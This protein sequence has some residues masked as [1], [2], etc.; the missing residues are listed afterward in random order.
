MTVYPSTDGKKK[1]R[2][3]QTYN[4]VVVDAVGLAP[5]AHD[6]VV[7]VGDEDDLVDPFGFELVAL[8]DEARDVL[9]LA[10]GREGARDGDEDDFFVLELCWFL[11]VPTLFLCP[12]PL[13]FFFFFFLPRQASLA[14]LC[15]HR[16]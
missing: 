11:L 10:R 7:V 13:C 8:G 14:H 9:L 16:T 12:S 4:K 6:P 5:G 2:E 3:N 15:W 1:K